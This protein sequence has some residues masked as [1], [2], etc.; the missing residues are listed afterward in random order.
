MGIIHKKKH[1]MNVKKEKCAVCEKTC[2]RCTECNKVLSLGNYAALQGKFFCKPHFKQLFQLK[3]NY[4][5][6]F[7]G[8][9]H[10]KK[11]A[12]QQFTGDADAL[13][14]AEKTSMTPPAVRKL[15]PEQQRRGGSE[16]FTSR[17]A[18]ARPD[19]QGIGRGD[20][21]MRGRVRG[22][23]RGGRGRGAVA[24][25]GVPANLNA[26]VAG[27]PVQPKP[28][29]MPIK[30]KPKPLEHPQKARPKSAGRAPTLRTTS[31]E[32][33]DK[34]D[35]SSAGASAAQAL[36]TQNKEK[37][38]K[39]KKI[40]E[41][42]KAKAKKEA[43]EKA[44]KEAAEKAKKEAE[45]KAKQAAVAKQ[46]STPTKKGGNH[47]PLKGNLTGSKAIEWLKANYDDFT[48]LDLSG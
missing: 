10:K 36:L 22:R 3:G 17:P 33:A 13:A 29:P 9:Q 37:E 21:A 1:I 7:G 46:N 18:Q 2:L 4:D 8:E 19:A 15:Q 45:N 28:K 48:N 14:A 43:D 27:G 40:E 39:Q 44:K 47:P 25:R 42:Q 31:R 5:E 34:K 26:I 11:W 41:E 23:G 32:E 38:E 35:A 6:G 30:E 12:P 24:G 20:P 16:R